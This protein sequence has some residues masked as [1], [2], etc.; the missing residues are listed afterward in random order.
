[1]ASAAGIPAQ[2]GLSAR[3]QPASGDAS[4]AKEYSPRN[5]H[6]GQLGAPTFV[7]FTAAEGAVNNATRRVA[8]EDAADLSRGGEGVAAQSMTARGY[9][10]LDEP[11]REASD[12]LPANMAASTLN[13]EEAPASAAATSATLPG[14]ASQA[15]APHEVAAQGIEGAVMV[16][17]GRGGVGMPPQAYGGY[18]GQMVQSQ[19]IPAQGY[20][21]HMARFQGY[22]NAATPAQGMGNN[23]VSY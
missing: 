14:A 9:F 17:Q 6:G 3:S 21:G 2:R 10:D 23:Q 7:S 13:K 12:M 11:G 8:A 20:G 15:S 22:G 5:R 16:P 4:V 18:E 19:G 1:M